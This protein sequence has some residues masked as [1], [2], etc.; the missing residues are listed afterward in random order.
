MGGMCHG[1]APYAMVDK[2][3]VPIPME[4]IMDVAPIIKTMHPV[5]TNMI[6]PFPAPHPEEPFMEVIEPDE[7]KTIFA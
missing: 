2:P 5:A 6:A 1:L 4:I 3:A 7:R